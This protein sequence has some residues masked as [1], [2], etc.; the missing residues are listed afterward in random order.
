MDKPTC[1]MPA[2]EKRICARGLCSTHYNR[3]RASDP[4]F[5][6]SSKRRSLDGELLACSVDSCVE[7]V[8]ASGLCLRH[9]TRKRKHG[10]FEDVIVERSCKNCGGAFRLSFRNPGQQ[11][12]KFCSAGCRREWQ[13]EYRR[14]LSIKARTETML[15]CRQCGVGFYSDGSLGRKYCSNR[16]ATRYY[17]ANSKATCSISGCARSCG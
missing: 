6:R 4:D 7:V 10:S 3:K 2:C 11:R 15:S 9:Y 8:H 13:N 16:C 12:N 5:V 1:S 14:K 17:R